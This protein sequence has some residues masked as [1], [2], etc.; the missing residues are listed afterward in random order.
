MSYCV[1]LDKFSFYILD[2]D[3]SNDESLR[4][5]YQ[6]LVDLARCCDIEAHTCIGNYGIDLWFV[7]I[8]KWYE[9]WSKTV[10]LSG[11]FFFLCFSNPWPSRLP[12]LSNLP[13][14]IWCVL[15][16]FLFNK[17]KVYMVTRWLTREPVGCG[18]MVLVGLPGLPEL[19]KRWIRPGSGFRLTRPS[20]AGLLGLVIWPVPTSK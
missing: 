5:V 6:T 13:C 4:W 19:L 10:M 18:L 16:Y 7:I 3:L 14:P 9:E 17:K 12:A 1:F 2:N 20:R 11:Y 8:E 15:N